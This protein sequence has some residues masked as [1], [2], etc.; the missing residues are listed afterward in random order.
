MESV[1]FHKSPLADYL[2][3]GGEADNEWTSL[4]T[5]YA[6]ARA[7]SPSFAPRGPPTAYS[8]FR[9]KLPSALKLDVSRSTS[10][11]ARIHDTCSSAL[12]SRLGRTENAQFLEQF[13]YTIIASQL[14]SDHPK[15]TGYTS[16][17][18]GPET[19]GDQEHRVNFTWE[20]IFL[21]AGAAF[22][23]VL[24]IHLARS[25]IR[26][27]S[28][29]WRLFLVTAIFTIAAFALYMVYRTQYLLYVRNQAIDSAT[30]LVENAHSLDATTSAA[31][32]L[33][34]EVELVSRGYRISSPLP[35]ISRLDEQ[36]Q[37]RRCA[38][39]RRTLRT[40]INALL[41][42]YAES[43]RILR[44]LANEQDLER[45]H[46]I[47]EV[48]QSDIQEIEEF[49]LGNN[50]EVEDSE[51]LKPLKVDLQK[52][53]VARKL[54]LCSLLA[55]SAD[56]GKPDF[57]RWAL[58]TSTMQALSSASA[59]AA[60]SLSHILSEEER[61]STPPTPKLPLTPNHVRLRA[62]LRKV[63]SLSHGIRALQAK[64]HIL[65]EESDHALSTSS[66]D[67]SELGASLLSQ[68]DSIGADLKCLTQEWEDGRAA[69]AVN[70]D[71]N[72]RRISSSSAAGL[73]LSRSATP[74]S[75]GGLTA[76]G[77]NSPSDALKILNGDAKSRS[78][79]IGAASSDEEVFEA[80][81]LPRQRS[82]LTREERIGKMREERVRQA[83]A[84]EKADANRSI[85]KEL[86]TV[87]KLRPR[88]RTTGRLGSMS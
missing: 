53:H 77:G 15:T 25:I 38:R 54:F 57:P 23:F 84:R 86:E 42:P 61:F 63:S 60:Y 44:P 33:I 79:S 40:S 39:L 32:T 55:L 20:G 16:Y 71:R 7:D 83:I 21:T 10:A 22:A 75:L 35:P 12:N 37:T 74:N 67:V 34:Q 2:E 45:Y 9:R 82:T 59:S 66:E 14:F 78:S 58:A 1:I 31:I 5:G 68:Y 11:V 6:P 3:G 49:A 62:Q 51:N 80:I 17:N 41:L 52:L 65:R 29:G 47:Y 30:S 69:L 81:A 28:S 56:G 19:L 13:R 18:T 8:K 24:A 70:I 43:Y 76:V 85:L 4:H 87:I 72:D 26:A 27:Y 48:T 64:M 36:S 50:I 88:G 73:A 46:D